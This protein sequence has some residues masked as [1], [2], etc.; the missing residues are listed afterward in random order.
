MIINILSKDEIHKLM[1]NDYH[2]LSSWFII[3]NPEFIDS[4]AGKTCNFSIYKDDILKM[5][6]NHEIISRFM[7]MPDSFSYSY[8][9]SEIRSCKEF[10]ID[11]CGQLQKNVVKIYRKQESIDNLFNQL[12]N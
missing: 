1:N 10:I 3:E 11:L 5:F 6:E 4:I 2:L 7:Y 8:Y 9:N 12:F